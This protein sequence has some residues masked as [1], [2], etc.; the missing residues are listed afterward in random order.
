MA[1]RG[2]ATSSSTARLVE[3]ITPEE[4][5]ADDS[6]DL[7]LRIKDDAFEQMPHERLDSILQEW[8]TATRR[9]GGD[10]GAAGG[11]ADASPCRR[12]RRRSEGDG[13]RDVAVV[14]AGTGGQGRPTD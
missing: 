10:A 12:E 1:W 8:E 11:G 4:M 5:A 14:V 6:L 3:L 13:G 2:V 9:H 7:M